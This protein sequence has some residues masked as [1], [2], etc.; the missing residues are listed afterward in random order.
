LLL[1]HMDTTILRVQDGAKVYIHFIM[2]NF[3]RTIL[4]WKASLE[5]NS[6]MAMLNLREVCEKFNLFQKPIQL[7]CDD[8]SENAGEVDVFL[9]SPGLFIEKLIAQVDITFSNSM[10]EAVNKKMKYEFLFPKK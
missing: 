8:G 4:G 1:L 2:D 10:I 9:R 5:W 3:S 7:L 6:K